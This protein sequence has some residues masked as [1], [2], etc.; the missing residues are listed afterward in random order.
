MPSFTTT[1]H[2]SL[3][4][5]LMPL[6]SAAEKLQGQVNNPLLFW[7]WLLLKLPAA[8]FAGL[9]M[10]ELS[11]TLCRTT[12]PYG[13]RSQNPFR[14]TY[15][16]AQAMAAEMSTGAL[17]LLHTADT[18]FSTLIVGMKAT[19]GKKA[20]NT[21]IFTCEGGALVEKA[22]A[23]ARASGEP[24]TISLE[25]IGR[26]QDGTEVSRFVFTWSVK[27]KRSQG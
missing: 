8:L 22:V 5:T 3:W 24:R 1:S 7:F 21:A 14:S 10:R 27:P 13:W 16:A 6:S 26:M 18:P 19:F 20:T 11:A 17:V 4:I 25:S 23:E 12:V 9:R 15:F 2:T